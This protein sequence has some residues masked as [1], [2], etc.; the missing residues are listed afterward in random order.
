MELIFHLFFISILLTTAELASN[1]QKLCK[2]SDDQICR[3]KY[4]ASLVYMQ[5][6][7]PRECSGHFQKA[8]SGGYCSRNR[9]DCVAIKKI[10]KSGTKQAAIQAC[11]MDYHFQPKDVCQTRMN[12]ELK[13]FSN[14]MSKQ[15][16]QIKCPCPETHSF[17]CHHSY[18]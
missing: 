8:C 9:R 11:R 4:F 5:S 1:S 2:L 13:Q 10:L 18:C 14:K 3:G 16:K 7:S 12:C 6:C 17:E 15:S